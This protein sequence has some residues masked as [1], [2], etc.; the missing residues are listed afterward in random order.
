MKVHHLTWT[1]VGIMLMLGM[2]LLVRTLPASTPVWGDGP[3]AT[4]IAG[5]KSNANEQ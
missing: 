5:G 3:S 4:M 2:F 1:W